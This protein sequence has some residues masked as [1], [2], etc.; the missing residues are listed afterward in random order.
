MEDIGR[1]SIAQEILLTA[2]HCLLKKVKEPI[3]VDV[4]NKGN[5]KADERANEGA[6]LHGGDMAQVRVGTVQQER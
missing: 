5:E 3:K 1:L 4:D 2:F 6:M